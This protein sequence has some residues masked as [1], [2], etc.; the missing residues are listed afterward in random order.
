MKRIRKDDRVIIVKKVN[1]LHFFLALVTYSEFKANKIRHW[2]DIK[3]KMRQ[4]MATWHPF[5]GMIIQGSDRTVC[6]RYTV[7]Q[8]LSSLHVRCGTDVNGKSP[9]TNSDAGEA[10]AEIEVRHWAKKMAASC[11]LIISGI[12]FRFERWVVE[13][14]WVVDVSWH[15]TE[16]CL[17]IRGQA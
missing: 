9:R 12:R 11:F 13:R 5:F 16:L 3:G 10:R 17:T 7:N 14:F 4:D 2:S 1:A 6:I 8:F 15:N